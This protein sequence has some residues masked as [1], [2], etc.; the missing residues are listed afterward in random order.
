ML[1]YLISNS[2]RLWQDGQTNLTSGVGIV[3]NA[4]FLEEPPGSAN[5]DT[6]HFGADVKF[7][8]VTIFF[9]FFLAAEGIRE[10]ILQQISGQDVK[11]RYKI[12]KNWLLVS[13]S[14]AP[15]Y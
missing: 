7:V 14:E 4:A 10:R 9:F 6:R 2:R 1:F 8:A 13:T 12:Y 15:L 5:D 3:S 11:M